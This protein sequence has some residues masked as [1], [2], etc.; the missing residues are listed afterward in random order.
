MT[1]H[2]RQL[3]DGR[4]VSRLCA[5]LSSRAVVRAAVLA[6]LSGIAWL[7]GVAAAHADPVAGSASEVSSSSQPSVVATPVIDPVAAESEQAALTPVNQLESATSSILEVPAELLRDKSEQDTSQSASNVDAS[8]DAVTP[9][10]TVGSTS[11]D[12]AAGAPAA[13]G[14]ETAVNPVLAPLA[15]A[16]EPAM[17]NLTA[18]TTGVGEML[19]GASRPVMALMRPVDSVFSALTPVGGPGMLT[20]LLAPL[21]GSV[22]GS[23]GSMGFDVDNGVSFARQHDQVVTGSA[24]PGHRVAGTEISEDDVP[25]VPGAMLRH[26]DPTPSSP[27][28]GPD[29]GLTTSGVIPT[30]NNLSGANPFDSGAGYLASTHTDRDAEVSRVTPT[31]AAFGQLPDHVADPAVAP[32]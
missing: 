25:W 19:T 1:S 21:T 31:T 26:S 4:R 11:S 17:G 3:R 10:T 9:D 5:A 20:P 28:V 23:F 18:V 32:D 16:V 15:V 7:A 2:D 8:A 13:D 12:H 14:A 6:G 29:F 27:G 30:G 22:P 24:E